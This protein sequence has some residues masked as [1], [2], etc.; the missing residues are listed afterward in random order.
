MEKANM[1]N[2][3]HWLSIIENG[4]STAEQRKAI[5]QLGKT[6]DTL[7][8]TALRRKWISGSDELRKLAIRSLEA[9]KYR[10]LEVHR[11]EIQTPSRSLFDIIQTWLFKRTGNFLYINH[12]DLDLAQAGDERSLAYLELC[13]VFGNFDVR[14]QAVRM[15][16]RVG[17]ERVVTPLI[18]SLSDVKDSVR[19][20]ARDALA[21]MGRL[22]LEPLAALCQGKIPHQPVARRYAIQALG[23]IGG[24]RAIDALVY[25]LNDRYY[26]VR[27]YAV[28]ELKRFGDKAVPRLL[29]ALKNPDNTFRVE[30]I[31]CLDAFDDPDITESF[32]QLL[33]DPADRMRVAVVRVLA[34]K[35]DDEVID[36]L[37]EAL[38]DPYDGVR[39]EAAMAFSRIRVPRAIE[40]LMTM[41]DDPSLF[42]RNRAIDALGHSGDPKAA[43]ALVARLDPE[44]TRD[45]IRIA[46]ALAELKDTRAI[47]PLADI[48]THPVFKSEKA[49]SA[50]N[51]L[52]GLVILRDGQLYCVKCIARSKT[53]KTPNYNSN[54]FYSD[55]FLYVACRKCES[56]L[57]FS[58]EIQRVVLVLD[59]NMKEDMTVDGENLLVNQ[60]RQEQ[61]T[62]FDEIRIIDADDYQVERF[63]MQIKNDTDDMRREWLP[64]TLVHLNPKL[65]LSQ[66]K[67]NM[68]RDFFEV[69]TLKERH[70]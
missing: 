51:S 62:D 61:L 32:A 59:R 70:A 30:V 67:I 47:E 63:A 3:E 17:G 50:L 14:S 13:L 4:G 49:L 68:L 45:N 8:I 26:Y 22:A 60:L 38:K 48:V 36:R 37:I 52:K 34:K 40:P 33:K 35:D 16:A 21:G 9:I 64:L 25:C 41:L 56:N 55:S 18:D 12:I 20:A 2:Q 11:G 28:N 65:P 54:L 39:A 19:S 69:V 42:A 15:L 27:E 7:A 46:M 58:E 43:D 31:N 10:F 57:F 23:K 44:S 1:D 66:S 5:I 24:H 29:E 53:F 6:G